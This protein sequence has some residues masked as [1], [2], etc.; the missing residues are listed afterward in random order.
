MATLSG[1]NVHLVIGG[2]T[3]TAYFTDVE[4]S[5]S[6]ESVDVT[7]GGGREHRQRNVGLGDTGMTITLVYD[8]ANIQTYIQ[9][10]KPGLYTVEYGPEGNTVGKPKH[11]QD[12]ILTGAPFSVSVEKSKVAFQLSFEAAEAPTFDMFNGAVY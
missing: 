2:T 1:N 10:L 3:V 9:K 12:F 11:I 8:A 6:V 4:L 5:P 7:A